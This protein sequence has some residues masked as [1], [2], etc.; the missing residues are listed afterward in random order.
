MYKITSS[1]PGDEKLGLTS[2]M[3][4]ASVSGAIFMAAPALEEETA[5]GVTYMKNAGD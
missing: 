3:R 4:R 2:Q 1:F 5:R